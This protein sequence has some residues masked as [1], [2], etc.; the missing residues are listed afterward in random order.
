MN[1]SEFNYMQSIGARLRRTTSKKIF[2]EGLTF[3]YR[4]DIL[5]MKV[6]ERKV[7]PMATSKK[8]LHDALRTRYMDLVREALVQAGE[9]ILVT[10]TNE[11]TLPC[12][13]AEGNDEFIVLTFKVP[14]GSRDGDPYDGYAVAEEY[15]MKQAERA[16][17]AKAAAEA[18]AKKVERD[19]LAREA[20]AKAKAEREKGE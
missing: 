1:P 3:Y 2:S 20:K 5:Y 6:E 12:V 10:G 19:R 17:K 9:D 7:Q 13:D 8:S 16:E 4:Y 18:K 14:T 11:F 15:R